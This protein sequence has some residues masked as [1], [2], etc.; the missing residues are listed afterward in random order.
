[1]ATP[2]LM[3]GLSID[4][5]YDI[6]PKVL[7][8]ILG[9]RCHARCTVWPE[10]DEVMPGMQAVFLPR[11]AIAAV[12]PTLAARERA[13]C[14]EDYTSKRVADENSERWQLKVVTGYTDARLH[15]CVHGFGPDDPELA[16]LEWNSYLRY[17]HVAVIS[18]G[19]AECLVEVV[20]DA[21]RNEVGFVGVDRR[22][23]EARPIRM[24]FSAQ[25]Q[26]VLDICSAVASALGTSVTRE[27]FA[28]AADGAGQ[29]ATW[30][31][32]MRWS[33]AQMFGDPRVLAKPGAILDLR[34]SLESSLT[35]LRNDWVDVDGLQGRGDNEIGAMWARTAVRGF[36]E[37]VRRIY[38]GPAGLPD[39]DVFAAQLVAAASAARARM[40]ENLDQV[41]SALDQLMAAG[42]DE[43]GPAAG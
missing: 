11:Q 37:T 22:I 32:A 30:R 29:M 35:M 13:F 27:L 20:R 19:V 8:S 40:T 3:P 36:A 31:L 33:A 4:Y 9:V 10:L 16:A 14:E 25:A 15:A 39:V 41:S 21:Y 34:R 17:P 26:V 23:L 12:H 5:V 28:L 43:E 7:T 24:H 2:Q 38:A 42:G 18:E 6:T 1:M